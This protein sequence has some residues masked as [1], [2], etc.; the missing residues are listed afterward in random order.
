MATVYR[1]LPITGAVFPSSNAAGFAINQ[2]SNFPVAVLTF[3]AGTAESVHWQIPVVAYGSGNLTLDLFWYADTAN[4][5]A[6]VVG[7]AIAAITP[8]T[9]SQD[10][11]TDALATEATVT[12]THLGTTGQR[13]HQATITISSLDSLANADFVILKLRRVAA[14]AADT[15]TGDMLLVGALLS[16]SDV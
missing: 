14:D 10:V 6:V 8:N 2:G 7:A 16:Y 11:E 1:E 9:D 13:L 5:G 3:D 15:M 12:D 4:S